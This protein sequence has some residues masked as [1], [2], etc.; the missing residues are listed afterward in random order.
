MSSWEKGK[1]AAMAISGVA[2][3]DGSG[4]DPHGRAEESVFHVV[5]TADDELWAYVM[6]DAHT[7]MKLFKKKKE[8]ARWEGLGSTMHAAQY[9]RKAVGKRSH[10]TWL[11]R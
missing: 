11:P 8:A 1:R 10:R 9:T 5:A 3:R 6:N 4:R 7:N 2:P